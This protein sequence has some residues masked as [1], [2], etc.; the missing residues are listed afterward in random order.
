M[1]CRI[2]GP[3]PFVGPLCAACDQPKLRPSPQREGWIWCFGCGRQAEVG[4]IGE[5]DVAAGAAQT[6]A[7]LR[8]K[9]LS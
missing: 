2:S 4:P 7:N 6:I 9:P 5:A 1:S 3:F 8:P